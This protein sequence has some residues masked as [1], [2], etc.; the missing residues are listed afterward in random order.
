MSDRVR[1]WLAWDAAIDHGF[2][3]QIA[4]LD[5]RV[6]VIE[7][8]YNDG[9]ELR[10]ARTRQD[11]D[12]PTREHVIAALTDA[13]SDAMRNAEVVFGHDVP[14][15]LTARADSLRW[16]QCIGSG[17]EHIW[18]AGLDRAG[19][20]VTN[21]VGVSAVPMA[22]F[23]LGRVLA[24]WK[25]FPEIDERARS[26][27]VGTG[28]RTDARR[29]DDGYRRVGCDRSCARRAGCRARHARDR[30]SRELD[31]RDDCASRRLARWS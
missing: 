11:V 12:G 8:A 26:P 29:I 9:P 6:E 2:A 25:R 20:T 4:A 28:I 14:F 13:Q 17:F 1:V 22:E 30:E 27:R 5:P 16:V 3:A 23:V 10:H 18:G 31:T 7:C 24:L 21:A 19:I 15:D